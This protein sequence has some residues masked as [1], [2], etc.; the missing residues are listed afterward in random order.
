MFQQNNK[1]VSD[2]KLY[3]VVDGK[4]HGLCLELLPDRDEEPTCDL[5]VLTYKKGDEHG[6]YM[7][8][9][10]FSNITKLTLFDSD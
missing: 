5:T 9:D 10:S 8:F 1:F 6:L 4:Y 7:S 3:M 2:L